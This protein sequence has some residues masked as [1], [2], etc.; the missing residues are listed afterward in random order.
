M[1]A[2]VALSNDPEVVLRA[3]HQARERF[4]IPSV[5]ARAELPEQLKQLQALGVRV[6]QPAMAMAIGLEGALN[7]PSALLMLSDKSD[8]FDLAD[9]PLGNPELVDTTLRQLHLPGKALVLGVRR[10]GEGEIVVPHGDTVLREGDVLMLCGNPQAL[11]EA[12]RWI[13]GK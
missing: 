12:G 2:L 3:C 8:E 4:Q 1:R 7:F 6:V 5:V 9:A 11:A 10:R 13:A